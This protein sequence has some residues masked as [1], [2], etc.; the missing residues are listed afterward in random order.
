P[1]LAM[2]ANAMAGD[3]EKSLQAGM[4]DHIA[5]PINV[6]NLFHTLAKWVVPAEPLQQLQQ[7]NV[8]VQEKEQAE[9]PARVALKLSIEA[10]SIEGLSTRKGL[11]IA[12]GNYHLY[13][14]ILGMFL[15]Q[16][17]DFIQ[18]FHDARQSDDSNAAQRCAHTLKGVAAN[19]GATAVQQAA[20][21]LEKTCDNPA[22][23]D[24]IELLLTEI[25]KHL[26]PLIAGLEL[27]QQS[28]TVVDKSAATQGKLSLH[29]AMPLLQRLRLLLQDSDTAAGEVLDQL[30]AL[31]GA[32]NDMFNF[33]KHLQEILKSI[34]QYDFDAALNCLAKLETTIEEFD[35]E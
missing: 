32:S 18:Q 12:Q 34:N 15:D 7:I 11:T 6:D 31:P 2:T 25:N 28:T 10:L 14:K 17:G 29:T 23:S 27:L 19:I 22:S 33:G 24:E 8:D 5:K 20:A 3:R 35:H 21:T 1:I 9:S 16:Q 4:N 13:F 26:L 30:F